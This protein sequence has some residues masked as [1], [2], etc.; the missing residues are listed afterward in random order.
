MKKIL[1]ELLVLSCLFMIGCKKEEKKEDVTPSPKTEI[2]G[3]WET[4]LAGQDKNLTVEDI[5]IFNEAKAN[6][7]DLNFDLVAILGKQVVA[8]TNYMYLAKGYQDGEYENATYKI[9]IVYHDLEGKKSITKVSDFDYTKYVN[10]IIDDTNEQ[11]SGGWVVESTNKEYTLSDE[12]NNIFEKATDTLTGMNF[13]PV[14]ILGKQIVAGTNYAI[15][16]FGAATV[17]DAREGIYIL[18]IYED[19]QGN[20]ELI[21]NAYVDL[22]EYNK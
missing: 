16:C 12:A 17:P 4:L 2:V 7:T 10:K 13:K 18:T 3:G 8:G 14:A 6:Y 22:A 9:V 21:G 19:L 5:N 20:A 15:L 1:I 11:L